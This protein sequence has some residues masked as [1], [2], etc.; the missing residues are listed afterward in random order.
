MAT[1][2]DHEGVAPVDNALAGDS[3]KVKVMACAE[4]A[5]IGKQ[6]SGQNPPPL[7]TCGIS[8]NGSWMSFGLAQVSYQR[9]QARLWPASIK[10]N[11]CSA[12]PA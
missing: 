3:D 11:V 2:Q 12:A 4:A 7:K 10:R 9:S 5:R 6:D 1:E 8:W